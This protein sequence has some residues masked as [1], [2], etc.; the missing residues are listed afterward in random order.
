MGFI[1][2][3]SCLLGNHQWEKFMGARNI[4]RGKFSQTYKCRKCGK[5]K[6]K[7]F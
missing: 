5:L 1:D 4:G 3:I 2:K 7:K 6:E